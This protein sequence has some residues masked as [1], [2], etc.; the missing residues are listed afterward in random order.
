[1]NDLYFILINETQNMYLMNVKMHKKKLLQFINDCE[2]I[3][4]KVN[5][6]FMYSIFINFKLS[7]KN[8]TSI[9][10]LF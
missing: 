8:P 1:M 2:N 3:I 10:I 4:K 7:N 9:H 5:K 6:N